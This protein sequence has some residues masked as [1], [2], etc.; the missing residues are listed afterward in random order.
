MTE[1]VVRRAYKHRFYPTPE[2][3][4]LLNRTFGC[5]RKV[6]NMALELRTSAYAAEG[7]SVNYAQTDAALTAWKKTEELAFLNEVSTVPLQQT[8]RHLQSA[9]SAFF[10]RRAGYPRFKSKHKSAQRQ[11]SPGRHS[12]GA[13]I[14]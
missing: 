9:F 5:A 1:R 8:L 2:Q 4:D 6:Y 13:T 10:G 11:R 3:A 12:A 14:S 7:R